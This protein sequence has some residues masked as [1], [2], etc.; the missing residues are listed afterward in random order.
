VKNISFA[1]KVVF[2][3][4]LSGM[5]VFGL[6]NFAE[7]SQVY[8]NKR[9]G[10][11]IQ[12][13]D[14]WVKPVENSNRNGSVTIVFNSDKK[15]V[16]PRFIINFDTLGK[17]E[18]VEEYA[19]FVTDRLKELY[20]KNKIN[21]NIIDGPREVWLRGF[22]GIRSVYEVAGPVT[23]KFIDYKIAKDSVVISLTGSD[24]GESF[25]ESSKDFEKMA[26]SF[27]FYKEK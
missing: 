2:L 22:K 19:D 12:Y 14:G 5:A 13:P 25:S 26:A 15:Q 10:F 9:F 7:S 6:T 18:N 24:A 1:R 21:L 8:V 17:F 11:E 4:F 16:L 3:L 20:A 27:R 23:I